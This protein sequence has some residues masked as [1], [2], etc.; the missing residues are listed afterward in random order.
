MRTILSP[1]FALLVSIWLINLG[2]GLQGTILGMRADLE[3][4]D[5]FATGI[6]M[7][8]YFLGYMISIF[9]IPPFINSVG[10]IRSFA[11]FASLSSAATLCHAVF[12]DPYVWFGLRTITGICFGG[13]ILVGESWLNASTGNENRGTVFSIYM[14]AVLS[15]AALS[16]VMINLTPVTSYD[17]FILVSV[18]L[19]VSLVPLTLGRKI[20]APEIMESERMSYIHLIRN[21]PLGSLGVLTSGLVNG[22]LW[23][24]MAV[25]CV[26]MGMKDSQTS[27]VMFAVMF[28]GM[29]SL[30]P[31]GK[32]SDIIDRRK[33]ILATSASTFVVATLFVTGI[34]TGDT[35]IPYLAGAIGLAAFPLYAI[36]SS[37]INDYL[38]QEE[39]VPACG[40]MVLLYGLGALVS[41][42][43]S[44]VF[45][46]MVGPNGMFLFILIISVPLI[47][48][49]SYRIIQK[50]VLPTE[51]R[52][53][54]V[55]DMPKVTPSVSPL[56]PRNQEAEELSEEIMKEMDEEEIEAMPL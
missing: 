28:G 22:A 31:T 23:T 35:Y 53:D 2:G 14:L 48:L 55:F 54:F 38:K 11:A 27:L 9:I 26:R 33:I 19:S 4:F 42:I 52:S 7:S 10:H 15:A 17:L 36:S 40:S 18:A 8:S 51:E 44:A 30:W 47:V 50:D 34:G 43:V 37:H 39:F 29:L 24:M 12:I 25:Y 13:L 5:L 56:D 49:A 16:Q 1:F 41:P 45:M 21:H 32:L 6:I 20:A 3:N 46:D